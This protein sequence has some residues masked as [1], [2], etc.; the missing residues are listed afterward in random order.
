MKNRIIAILFSFMLAAGSLSACA[1]AQNETAKT[2]TS[3]AAVQS[4]A[5]ETGESVSEEMETAAAETDAEEETGEGGNA[6]GGITEFTDSCG[7]QFQLEKPLERIIVLNRQTAEAIQILQAQDK[8]IATGDTTVENNPYLLDYQ[9]LPDMGDTGELNI[10]AII[11]LQPDAVLVHTNRA[12]ELEDQLVPAGIAVIRMDNYQPER[13][14]EEMLLLGRILGKEQ[15]AQEFLE[16]KH[17]LEDMIAERVA[18]IGEDEKKTV[19]ALS[20]GFLNSD[21]GY[22]IFPCMS[23]DGEMGVG[24]GYSTILAGG[25]DA[26]PEIQYDPSVGDTTILVDE[27][28]ALSCNPQVLTLHGTWLGGYDCEDETEFRDVIDHIYEISSISQMDAGKNREV[29]IFH[30]DFLGASNR[31]IGVMQLCKYLYPE[32]FADL[33]VEGYAREYFENWLGTEYKGIWYYAAE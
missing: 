22:R 13:Y 16:Y 17:A 15:R 1:G 9:E 4:Q 31:H 8:V 28:Y 18:Q 30:T 3:T 29:Y 11:S 2:E 27:E 25:L 14:D 33:D 10:E 19:M 7:T 21:G 24:E 6:S 12:T 20:V 32:K 23:I 26:S 5:D